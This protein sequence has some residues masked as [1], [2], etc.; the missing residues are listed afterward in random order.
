[1][2]KIITVVALSFFLFACG[3]GT[4]TEVKTDSTSVDT[5]KVDTV[6]TITK[7]DSCVKNCEKK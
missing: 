3:N 1:M 2:K 5:V 7:S 6:K 4:V